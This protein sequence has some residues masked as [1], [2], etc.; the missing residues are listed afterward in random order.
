[1]DDVFT[2]AW[3]RPDPGALVVR[4]S[5]AV[6]AASA[7]RM[8]EGIAAARDA[9]ETAAGRVVIDLSEVSFLDSAGLAMLVETAS[10]CH[11][12]GQAFVLVAQGSA[13]L[14]PLQLTGLDKILTI[15]G[16]VTSALET[17]AAGARD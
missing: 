4:V 15:T 8:R 17:Q 1:M 13:V 7:R 14:R 11:Q 6:D 12:A 9:G 2:L 16:S 5:G 10:R 3:D